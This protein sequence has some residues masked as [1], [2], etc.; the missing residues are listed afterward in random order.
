MGGYGPVFYFI[1]FVVKIIGGN[2]YRFFPRGKIF[3]VCP[4]GS[5]S[6][7]YWLVISTSLSDRTFFSPVDAVTSDLLTFDVRFVKV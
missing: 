4:L 3:I 2:N 5:L 7:N 1:T 6:F